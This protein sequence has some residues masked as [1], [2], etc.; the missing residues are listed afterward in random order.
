VKRTV[1]RKVALITALYMMFTSLFMS[2]TIQPVQAAAQQSFYVSPLGD[3]NNNGTSDLPF[4]T[5]E[6]ARQAVREI[7]SAMTGDIHVYLK[8]GEYFLDKTLTFD[9]LD[10]GNN[11][12]NIIYSADA[13]ASPIISGGVD[14]STGWELYDSDKNIY[15]K[16]GVNWDFRQLYIGDDR[17]I[18]AREPNMTDEA[19]KGP[20]YRAQ[21]GEYPYVIDVDAR[22][23]ASKLSG[24]SAEMVIVQSWSQVRGRIDSI[25]E[26]TG[27]VDFKFPESGFSYNHHSQ[28]NSPYFFENALS[29][30]DAEGE[31]YV[32]PA[33]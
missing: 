27:K 17:G 19:V 23:W 18:R 4:R 29:L 25:N 33:E 13:G 32:D 26:T 10:S 7:N 30:L 3:D 9:S 8:D 24:T 22:S 20:Y 5:I 15:K 1:K 31:W 2:G 14:I 6:K 11:G 16:T 28:G 21:N 12:Y